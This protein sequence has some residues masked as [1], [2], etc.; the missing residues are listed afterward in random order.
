MILKTLSW[1]YIWRKQQFEKIHML[2]VHRS[3]TYNSQDVEA[4]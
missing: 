3:T 1:V 4:T 2:H